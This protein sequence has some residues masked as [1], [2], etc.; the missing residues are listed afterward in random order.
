M[1]KVLLIGASEYIGSELSKFLLKKNYELTEVDNLRRKSSVSKRS[2][3][4]FQVDYQ[5][6]DEDFL[7]SHDDCIWL[8]GHSSVK[9]SLDEPKNFF[10][11]KERRLRGLTGKNRKVKREI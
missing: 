1:K 10:E 4:F 8:A 2:K 9:D 3:N 11:R 6:L 7:N 5:S